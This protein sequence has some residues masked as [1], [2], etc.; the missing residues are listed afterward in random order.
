M[1]CKEPTDGNS[2]TSVY[3]C[4]CASYAQLPD[5][6]VGLEASKGAG[7]GKLFTLPKESYMKKEG[8]DG[9]SK[10][11]LTPSNEKFG[12]GDPTDYWVL[13][14]IFLQNYYSIYDYPNKKVG[15]I[16]SRTGGSGAATAPKK[17]NVDWNA[18]FSVMTA[19]SPANNKLFSESILD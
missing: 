19:P 3:Q 1:Q 11:L 12:N 4:S 8:A 15:L 16:Q 5:I 17:S 14:D 10:L 18:A 6:Q 9:C 2:L 13:G 7:D